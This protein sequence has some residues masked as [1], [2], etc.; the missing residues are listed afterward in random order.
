MKQPLRTAQAERDLLEIW[1]FVAGDNLAAAD[2]L[3]ERLEK[4]LQSLC[5][6]PELGRER[7]ELA[8]LLRSYPFGNYLVFYRITDEHIVVARVLHG[9]RDL[10]S[11]L[12]EE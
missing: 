5:E 8:P 12:L 1:S 7:S 10:P 4:V 9:A 6:N 3:I 2:R 11:L